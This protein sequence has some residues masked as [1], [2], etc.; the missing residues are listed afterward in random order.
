MS[1]RVSECVCVRACVIACVRACVCVRSS[2]I[3]VI[4]KC[5]IFYVQCLNLPLME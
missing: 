3:I 4:K 2:V 1:V 5:I